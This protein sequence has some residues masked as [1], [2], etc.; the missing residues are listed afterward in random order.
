MGFAVE[1]ASWPETCHSSGA[2]SIS[3]LL[4]Q[5][6][7]TYGAREG[8]I[9]RERWVKSTSKEFSGSILNVLIVAY[10]CAL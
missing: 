3:V 9:M 10:G 2:D 5:T 8:M 1:F 7:R 6:W 4:L